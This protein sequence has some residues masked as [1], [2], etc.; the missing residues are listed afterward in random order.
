M[1]RVRLIIWSRPDVAERAARLTGAG[2]E[3]DAAEINQA[4]LRTIRAEPPDA[5]VIDLDRAP[6]QGR[7][8]GIWLR[9]AAATRYVPLVFAGGA[10]DKVAGV[11]EH[12]PDAVLTSWED[13]GSAV[14]E[15]LTNPPAAPV[16]PGSLLAGYSGTP[17]PKKL[18]IT[19]GAQVALI[20]APES[21]ASALGDLPGGVQLEAASSAADSD[22]AVWFVRNSAM[23][24]T[25]I[26]EVATE[27]GPRGLWI[28]W[29]KQSSRLAGDLTQQ[30]VR[31]IGLDHGLVDFKIC[32]I[33]ETWSGLRFSRRTRS[34]TSK[35][36][37][38][39]PSN[40]AKS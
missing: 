8:I 6:S 37:P 28:A 39:K 35:N 40:P 23:L 32:A 10:P 7:D 15:A 9:S 11:R 33:D 17:L 27:L 5:V 29:P 34:C 20:D 19:T 21:F 38:P 36:R 1:A 26:D 30:L 25:R 22:L 12:L 14:A 31:K 3:V 16:V 18:G 4:A 2:H 13:V 24:E